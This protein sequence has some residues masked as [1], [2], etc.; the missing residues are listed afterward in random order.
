MKKVSSSDT[1]AFAAALKESSAQGRQAKASKERVGAQPAK[2]KM[3]NAG[4][5]VKMVKRKK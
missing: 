4:V 5:G 3:K 2:S 1:A